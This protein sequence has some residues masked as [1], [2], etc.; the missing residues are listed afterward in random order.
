MRELTADGYRLFPWE[1]LT[2]KQ[3]ER[4]GSLVGWRS[5]ILELTDG[6]DDRRRFAERHRDWL[7]APQ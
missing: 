5:E 6:P 7:I 4:I 1:E 2:E 3:L